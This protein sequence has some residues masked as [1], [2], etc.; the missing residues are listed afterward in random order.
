[1][2]DTL[3]TKVVQATTIL[4]TM[5]Y[6]VFKQVSWNRKIKRSLVDK[7]KKSMVSEGFASYAPILVN[8]DMVILDGQHRFIAAKELGIP[9]KYMI[10]A[11]DTKQDALILM[12]TNKLP[13]TPDDFAGYYAAKGNPYYI[14]L[15]DFATRH[16][17]SCGVAF[18]F[19]HGSHIHNSRDCATI[20]QQGKWSYTVEAMQQAE[21]DMCAI[22]KILELL[23]MPFRRTVYRAL[24]SLSK[25]P[26]FSWERM[27]DKALK[28]RD[29]AYPCSNLKGYV[30]MF[31]DLY[32]FKARTDSVLNLGRV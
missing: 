5:E 15:V 25:T 19:I 1:M 14:G 27:I 3:T 7:I 11:E 20:Y 18:T 22:V 4:E 9:V 17:V 26:G 24:I 23:N 12:N 13:W 31:L 30:Q 32:N 8:D 2:N 16:K 10:V 29:R 6:S 28:Y 21:K